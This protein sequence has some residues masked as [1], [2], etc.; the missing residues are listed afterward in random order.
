VQK[1]KVNNAVFL[2][3]FITSQ[4]YA[5]RCGTAAWFVCRSRAKT[6]EPI[7]ITFGLWTRAGPWNHV[8]HNLQSATKKTQQNSH[9]EDCRT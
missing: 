5:R 4:Y 1:K 8:G 3:V 9:T 2:P 6:D 7:F